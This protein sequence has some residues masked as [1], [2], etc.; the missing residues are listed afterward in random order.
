M[1]RK[2]TSRLLP[3]LIHRYKQTASV[4]HID[5][6]IVLLLP[7]HY[8]IGP[9]TEVKIWSFLLVILIPVMQSQVKVY[10]T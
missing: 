7:P 2:V 1:H 10:H 5:F 8:V 3:F 4:C 6:V 9:L